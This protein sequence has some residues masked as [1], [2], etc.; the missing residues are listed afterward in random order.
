MQFDP[1]LETLDTILG[2]RLSI[3]QPIFGYR[4]AID[5][6]LAANFVRSRQS[7]RVLD[8]GTGCG[9]IAAM[10]AFTQRPREVVAVELQPVLAGLAA[11]N[12]MLN[13]L[14]NLRAFQAD[15]CSRAVTGLVPGSFDWVVANPPYRAVG[16]GRESPDPGRRLARGAGGASLRDFVAAAARYAA[17]GGRV[18]IVFT[19]ARTADL[20]AEL[21]ANSL[22]PKRCRFVHP[23]ADSPATMILVEA[24]KGGGVEVS[25]EPPLILWESAGVYTAE[26]RAMLD[27]DKLAA[28]GRDSPS[29]AGGPSGSAA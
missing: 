25:I 9:V 24:R 27:G 28:P 10:I 14:D 20:L 15:I 26:A 13:R 17:N 4:F 2:G 8:L 18:A 5:S 11:R 1:R 19:A 23:Y 21:R 3:I 6:I 22:E 7:D 29:G 16:T 12:A